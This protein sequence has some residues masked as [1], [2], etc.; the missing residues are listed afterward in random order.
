MNNDV[1]LP[2]ATFRNLE[3]IFDTDPKAGMVGPLCPALGGPQEPLSAQYRPR[4]LGSNM[5]P[6]RAAFLLGACLM[7]RKEV[8]DEIGPFDE[9]MPLGA[10]DH[11]YSIRMKH[12]GYHLWVQPNVCIWHKG[13]ASD[14]PEW[15]EWGGKSWGAFNEK[16][17]GYF[18]TEE[19]AIKCHWGGEYFPEHEVGT[20][21]SEEE[22]RDRSRGSHIQ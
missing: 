19:E 16:W 8:F 10:D 17:G 21:W 4:A 18:A 6:F 7:Y 5:M 13:H 3:I 12:A 20:G 22:Y 9:T 11:D 1:Q 15:D 2:G 14:G